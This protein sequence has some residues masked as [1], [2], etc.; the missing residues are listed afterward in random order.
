MSIGF[1]GEGNQLLEGAFKAFLLYSWQEPTTRIR[2]EED[3]DVY[4]PNV[5]F[6]SLL[7]GDTPFNPE[8][9]AHFTRWIAENLWGMAEDGG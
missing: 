7:N 5:N 6:L 2:F 3:T 9:A 4:L 8:I 1:Y